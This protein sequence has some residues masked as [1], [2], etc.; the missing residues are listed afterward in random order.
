MPKK[1][2]SANKDVQT[3]TAEIVLQPITET[4]EKNYMPYV[5]SVIVSRAIPEIDGFKPAHR[6]ILF[7]MYK[8]GL[9]NGE[10]TKSANVVGQ[11]M[12]LNPH[13]DASIYE[14]LVRLTKANET[15]LH[16]FIDSKGTFGKHYTELEYAAPRYT[17]VKLAEIC[18][19]IFRGIDKDT[20]DF[21]DNYDNTMKEPVL[22]PTAFPNVL[23]SPNIG[24][25]VGMASSICSFNLA[26]ICDGTIQLLKNPDTDIDRLIDIIR[27]PDFSTGGNIIFNRDKYR[28]IFKGERGGI[29]IRSRYT[30]DK[31]N[32]CIEVLQIPYS[33]TIE[34]II[35]RIMQLIKE[36]KLKEI[37]D[38][39]D[40]IDLN[41]FKLAIDL[42]R[43]TDPDKLMNKLFRT[44]P[45]EDTF[46]CNFNILID[47]TPKQLG[48]KEILLEW[49]KFRLS[50]VKRELQ[51]DLERKNEKL[52]LLLGLGKILLDIDKAI[53]II[54]ET[55]LE[56]DVV[57]N[58]M[59][60]FDID[61]VQ[62]EFVA[63]IK[64][65][66]LNREHILNRIKDIEELQNEIDEIEKTLASETKQRSIIAKQLKEI[67]EKYAKPRLSQLLYEDEIDDAD[68]DAEE[69][70][71]NVH[72]IMTKEGYFKKITLQSL[73]GSDDQKLK[74]GDEV[75][76][77]DEVKNSSEL[78]FFSDRAQVYKT[79]VSEFEP[80]KSSLL[81]EFIPAKLGFDE[82]ERVIFMK[83]L[84]AY[85]E[86]TY[87]VFIFED[88]RGVKIPIT[89][90]QT[91]NNRRKLTGAYSENSPIVCAFCIESPCSIII[92]TN[93][94]RAVT[95]SSDLVPIKTTRSSQGSVLI[96]L[97]NNAKVVYASPEESSIFA[98]PQKYK[99]IKI[100]ATG[101]LLDEY[102]ISKNQINLLEE[103]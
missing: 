84:S 85:D 14:T 4:I 30:Y 36:G 57:P 75:V 61:Q 8:M 34:Q 74:E 91:K 50:S 83:C 42:R 11:V 78:I 67:K 37:T 22:L 10:R 13:G 48:V 21:V 33:T 7:T 82:G 77:S 44:T 65:R 18:N 19:E 9:L 98:N 16:P 43:G 89:A 103:K 87:M 6:K 29:R 3:K 54:R 64:L 81:G 12:K 51:F 73:R 58:L 55:K 71:Y 93:Q 15:L 76:V 102:D 90:Y 40:E 23:V 80:V 97:K 31:Q 38:I 1:I 86:N 66:N 101:V 56:K 20:V 5:M 69:E 52:H 46:D 32:N 59:E 92:A 47:G 28:E 60:G 2:K 53:K 35:K 96:N 99:K 100:P 17:E 49:I 45:L 88:G 68:D 24:V 27:A 26:E 63:E 25:A 79:R 39:R 62:A 94:N 72:I 70:D 95:I 41:G